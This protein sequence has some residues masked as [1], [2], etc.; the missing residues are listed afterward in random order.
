MGVLPEY[1]A[2]RLNSVL[3]LRR[4]GLY[5]FHIDNGAKMVPFA[6]Y[7]M[8][9]SYGNVGAGAFVS[10][11]SR[12]MLLN[13]LSSQLQVITMSVIL[14]V[15]STLGIWFNQSKAQF[16]ELYDFSLSIYIV[17]FWVQQP[18]NF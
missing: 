17:V 11:Q 1:Y 13:L 5:Q 3:Q 14:W 7:A 2:Q 6:G 10:E 15:S 12:K 18:Q 8:P 4:T 9:L 16:P